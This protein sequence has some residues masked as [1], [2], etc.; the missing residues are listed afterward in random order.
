MYKTFN[1][2][3]RHAITTFKQI[4]I[5]CINESISIDKKFS[6]KIMKWDG[7]HPDVL[8]ESWSRGSM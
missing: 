1:K 2:A 6:N 3:K 5:S 4:N 7:E 8:N